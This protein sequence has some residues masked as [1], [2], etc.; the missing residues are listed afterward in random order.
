MTPEE[1]EDWLAV[2]H[3]T[4]DELF[5]ELWKKGSGVASAT[6]N[7]VVDACLCVGWI[8]GRGN[9]IDDQRWTI[10]ITPRRKGSYWSDKNLK[11]FEE[12]RAVG[13]VQPAGLATWEA[14][15]PGTDRRYSFEREHAVLSDEE[16]DTFPPEARAFWEAQPPGYRKAALHWVTSAKRPET[17][18]KRLAEL[19]ADSGD[20][21]R[22][23]LL[24]R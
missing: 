13:R 5:V 10:R 21:L 20:G 16:W 15:D 3:A 11:R 9:R 17:R 4:A 18:V 23:K 6:W 1:L 24:R 2:N 14:R 19:V 7:D 12:L 8:D 22:I